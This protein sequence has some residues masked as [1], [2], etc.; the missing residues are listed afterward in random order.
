MKNL[1][2]KLV[3]LVKFSFIGLHKICYTFQ[4]AMGYYR[5]SRDVKIAAIKL[6]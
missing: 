6:Y 3:I 2:R 4:H 1:N 5:I